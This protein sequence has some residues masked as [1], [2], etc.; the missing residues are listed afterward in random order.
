[1]N[2]AIVGHGFVG[3]AVEYGF[4]HK[5]VN[6]TLI[7]P[8]YNTSVEDL[9]DKD[10]QAAFVCVPTP[11]S[12]DGK[13]DAS[14]VED[15]TRKLIDNTNALVILKS[16]V[17]PEIVKSLAEIDKYRFVYNPEFLTERNAKDDFVKADFHVFG[18]HDVPVTQAEGLYNTYSKCF[19]YNICVCS[20][21]EASFVKYA[22][23][24]F[25]ATKVT[26]F[27]QLKDQADKFGCNFEDITDIISQDRRIGS[28]H[29]QVPGPDGK[30]GFGG[31]CFPKD[32]NAMARFSNGEFSLLKNVLT[33]N[34]EYRKLYELDEREK[35]MNVTFGDINVDNG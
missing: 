10:I 3:Q 16:T 5:L 13:I 9:Y 27:N 4:E 25:L 34:S 22:I 2:I 31:A 29:M 6:A 15:V 26:F 21:V 17:T 18:G 35:E 24:T 1:M 14:I 33:I 23:N 8:K 30:R 11:M 28:S 19:M 20:A 7:D 12:D 32:T